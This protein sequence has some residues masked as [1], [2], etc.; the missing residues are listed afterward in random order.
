V[1]ADVDTVVIGGG[2]V[3][4]ACAFEL[5]QAG[6][7]L[8][9][10]RGPR[11]G[12]GASTRNSGVIHS[13]IYYPAGTL[14]ARL[15]VE[16]AERL[17]AW[18][19]GRGVPH[20]RCGKLVVA[21]TAEDLD[22]LETLRAQGEANGVKGLR[23][24]D[25]AA[26]RKFEPE[27]EGVQALQVPSAGILD[28]AGLVASLATAARERGV[29]ILLNAEALRIEGNAVESGRGSVRARFIVNAAGL[30]SGRF[31]GIPI[32]PCRGEYAAVVPSRRE[33]VKALVYPAPH[34]GPG[35]GVHFTRTVDGDLL[36]GP[37]ARYVQDP[38]DYE[39]DPTP[40]AAFWESARR[41]VP[42]LGIA[43]LRP[44]YAGI[45]AKLSGDGNFRDFGILKAGPVVHLAGIESPG[46]TASLAL[47]SEVAR[48]LQ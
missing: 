19:A 48:R 33:L 25:R 21:A 24:L 47:A 26:F 12:E 41:L 22:G 15:S 28:P 13:G 35:L 11:L 34:P 14:K 46:L 3:G 20:A 5:A 8:L 23:L 44:A 38:E 16:G 27:V 43:D 2:V 30:F 40:V 18:C 32:H 36:V 6:S 17:Y 9:L 42:A 45:R 37:N 1:A 29:E 39:G 7:V 31:S 4:L 10:E